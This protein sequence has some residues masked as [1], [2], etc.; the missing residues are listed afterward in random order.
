MTPEQIA[1]LQPALAEFLRPLAAYFPRRKTFGYLRTYLSGL[2]S[3][4]ERKSIEPMALRAEVSVRTLQEFLSQFVWDQERIDA[5]LSRRVADRQGRTRGLAIV[6]ASAHPKQGD[7]TPGVQRQ[8]CGE[9]GKHDN[10][11]IGQHLLYDNGARR[12]PFACVLASDLYL[13]QG[14]AQD[15]DRC[16]AA[17]I[18]DELVYRPKWMIALE[19]LRRVQVQGVKLAYVLFDEDYGR[20]PAFLLGL[21]ALGLVGVG[22][23]PPDYHVWTTAPCCRSG[24]AE[25]ASKEVG[26][27]PGHS[28]AFAGQAGERVALAPRTRGKMTWRLR[29][30]RV[31]LV[32]QSSQGTHAPGVPTDRQYWL[33]IADRPATGERKFF[34]SNA[35]ADADPA[36]LLKI[37]LE[38]WRVEQWFARAK[39]E[40][41]LGAFEVRTYQSLIRHWLISRLAMG[42]LAE[43]TVRLRGEKS[44]HHLRAGGPRRPRPGL[45]A[46]A[47]VAA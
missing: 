9:S 31:H 35:P 25:H 13:P 17:G 4:L 22:E 30:A 15:R 39:Q 36:E 8:Y 45:T 19:Q 28:P 34:V 18:P 21:D 7:K 37:G 29:S 11:V 16:R 12:N 27:L 14:W 5:H 23:V 6:D 38:R 42:F 3:D 47:P 2:L 24:R 33:L 43:Q 44:G 32:A 10:C 40:C 46:L 26:H 20:A 1:S 41:G